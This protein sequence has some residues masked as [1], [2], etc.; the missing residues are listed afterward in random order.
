MHG[1]IPASRIRRGGSLAEPKA[2]SPA[3][4]NHAPV[5]C[6]YEIMPPG[7]PWRGDT[8]KISDHRRAGCHTDMAVSTLPP[9]PPARP[10]MPAAITAAEAG[11]RALGI[12]L[13]DPG[14]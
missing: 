4:F 9:L 6:L 10:L 1:V 11:N 13:D 12:L 5:S 8:R 3:A 14:A 7:T 2:W